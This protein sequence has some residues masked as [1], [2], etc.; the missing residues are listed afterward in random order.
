MPEYMFV[1]LL[2]VCGLACR[3]N[4]NDTLEMKWKAW[5]YWDDL[6]NE[7]QLRDIVEF[8]KVSFEEQE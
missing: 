1:E 2:L 8:D 5:D 6:I 7:Y 3:K 4:K